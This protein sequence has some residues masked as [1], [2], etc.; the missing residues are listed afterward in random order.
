MAQAETIREPSRETPVLKRTGVLVV[1]GGAAGVSAAVAAAREGADVT[2]V[3]RYG[4]LGGLATGG[5][6]ALLLTLDDGR[7]VPVIGGLCQETVDR[8]QRAGGAY[9]PPREQW[10]SDDPAQVDDAFRWGLV[11]GG[12]RA[13]HR[14]RYSVAYD[15]EVMRQ[16]LAEMVCEAG[17]DLI[18]HMWGAD[19]LRSDEPEKGLD[20]VLFQSKAGRTAILADVVI[21]AT[22]DGDVFASAGCRFELERVHPWLWFRLGG[23]DGD[24]N[25][26]DRSTGY[27]RTTNPGQVLLPWG[28]AARIDRR[29]DATDPRDLTFAELEC[30]RLVMEEVEKLRA[31][32]PEMAHA[33]IC[34]IATQLGIT[35]SRR[36]VG[37]HVL[38]R[39]DVDHDFD[40]AIAITGHW[41]KYAAV[42]AIPYRCLHTA[43]APNLL[44]AG[45][46]ISVDHRVHHATKE[47]PACMAVGEAAGIAAHL[48]LDAGARASAVDVQKLRA[49]LRARGALLDYFS[50]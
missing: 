38:T 6:I 49:Q 31:S 2:L 40:D 16:V 25:E 48:A 18:F 5:L 1:G 12:M 32:R 9:H 13:S 15:P 8:L 21:D 46:H 10:G 41:T 45:R 39:D 34:N 43:A 24:P 20:G 19:A 26:I 22:G 37:E 36:L 17:V 11:W 30:R 35:E 3:E 50:G 42:Y 7:G 14:V 29:I 23:V 47:I 33:H 4:S 28:S 27:F 44:A